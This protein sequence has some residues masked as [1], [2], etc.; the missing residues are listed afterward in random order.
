MRSAPED[1][2]RFMYIVS[3]LAV[4][5]VF[6]VGIY[7]SFP[8]GHR[9]THRGSYELIP[10]LPGRLNIVAHTNAEA[11]IVGWARSWQSATRRRPANELV[12]H[13]Y[14]LSLAPEDRIWTRRDDDTIVFSS[15]IS[16]CRARAWRSSNIHYYG[17]LPTV[18]NYEVYTDPVVAR[19]ALR[20]PEPP[21]IESE[22]RLERELQQIVCQ[23][24]PTQ[25]N[26]F[27][28]VW[29]VLRPFMGMP[30]D[31]LRQH[32][33]HLDQASLLILSQG[34]CFPFRHQR[35]RK[36]SI[37]ESLTEVPQV[38]AT[39]CEVLAV[40][41]AGKVTA[42]S[43]EVASKLREPV[44]DPLEEPEK[45]TRFNSLRVRIELGYHNIYFAE[46]A[47]TNDD[48]FITVGRQ[49]IKLLRSPGY[50]AVANKAVDLMVAFGS[51]TISVDQFNH[52]HLFPRRPETMP[53]G[54]DPF[55]LKS[56]IFSARCI[57]E[58]HREAIITKFDNIN[59]DIYPLRWPSYLSA[60][61]SVTDWHYSPY[62]VKTNTLAVSL[63]GRPSAC[64]Y[65]K[66]LRVRL[67]LDGLWQSWFS[68][69]TSDNVY[70]SVGMENRPS[71]GVL[72]LAKSPA[73]GSVFEA[74]FNLETFFDQKTVPVSAILSYV[75]VYAT[76]GMGLNAN[77]TDGWQ[78]KSI[79]FDGRCADNNRAVRAN[80]VFPEGKWVERQAG[81]EWGL[82]YSHD[83]I[84]LERW[85]RLDW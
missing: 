11:A 6:N 13:I 26:L 57:E 41:I 43:P 78:I 67:T 27:Q 58:P 18:A 40:S 71:V 66:A 29:D 69:G 54:G 31:I 34:G 83:K 64:I 81:K 65:L 49:T 37:D 16:P 3:T 72:P 2:Q 47:G 70:L 38:N 4:S 1:G 48:I 10:I 24:M 33:P 55:N 53:T 21:L 45:C 7:G 84:G 23:E 30:I 63:P 44:V 82:V 22:R 20:Q 35:L 9:C 60:R 73:A 50:S 59:R 76:P 8:V 80:I 36:R 32:F 19:T 52:F 17:I 39:A 46:G 25:E 61:I 68:A 12:V 51:E 62:D 15:Y 85:I 79:I 56:L 28:G 5:S 74:D 14:A 42:L 77:Y 75:N